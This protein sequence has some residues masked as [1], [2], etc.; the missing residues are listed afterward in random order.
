MMRFVVLLFSVFLSLTVM[1]QSYD[2]KLAKESES[3][4]IKVFTSEVEGSNLDAFK[5]EM[6]VK[7]QLWRL[8]ALLNDIKKAP[9][10][11]ENCKSMELLEQK[12]EK[13]A[14]F[15]TVNHVP[16]PL[17][18][19]DLVSRVKTHVDEQTHAVTLN[20]SAVAGVVD[21]KEKL[22]RIPMLKGF[23]RFI[24]VSK[25]EIKVIYQVHADPGGDIPAWLANAVAVNNPFNTLKNM[26][27]ML[28]TND[29]KQN[30]P[31]GVSQTPPKSLV[32]NEYQNPHK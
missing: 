5:G 8:L 32:F 16:W 25:D 21:K 31:T 7:E 11:V 22:V 9:K 1:A 29:F 27:K 24:P 13:E 12:S 6:V 28:K 3:L 14:I 18:N 26:Q 15:Y 23:W 17:L 4:G 30:P 2:W 20:I 19:R 10:W